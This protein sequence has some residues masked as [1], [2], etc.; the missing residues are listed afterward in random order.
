MIVPMK[1]ASIVVL[2]KERKKALDS[3]KKIGVVHLEE[4]EGSG[5]TLA[6]FKEASNNAMN[7]ISI[8]SE[9]KLP[10]KHST[11]ETLSNEK[12]AEKCS[13]VVALSE[14]KKKLL[15]EISSNAAELERFSLWGDVVPE[16]FAYLKENDVSLRMFEIP[17]DK[18]AFI[19]DSVQTISVNHAKKIVR[20]V[21]INGGDDRPAVSFNSADCGK[22]KKCGKTDW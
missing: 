3:L 8:L 21:L 20:F 22:Y 11:A 17:E 14:Q 5:E 18:Y 1:K 2:S 19:D 16:D 12:I 15:E 10:K 4:V 9:I 6:S 7:A 13:R